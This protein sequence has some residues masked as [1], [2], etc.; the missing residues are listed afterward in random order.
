MHILFV[1]FFSL[2]MFHLQVDVVVPLL[3]YVTELTDNWQ[4]TLQKLCNT[5]YLDLQPLPL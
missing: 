5:R 4:L 1:T 3:L 2:F